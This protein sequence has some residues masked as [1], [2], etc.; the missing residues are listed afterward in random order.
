M[1]FLFLIFG[2]ALKST[3]WI[4]PLSG[5]V[6]GS[7]SLGPLTTDAASELDVLGHDS[8]TLGVDSAQVGVLE[9]T[10]EVSLAGL[11]EGHD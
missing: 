3:V 10:D 7:R 8:H 11:L 6:A 5:A 4:L 9:Q 2:V 1:S